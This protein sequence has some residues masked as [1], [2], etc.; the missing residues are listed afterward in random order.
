MLSILEELEGAGFVA[1]RGSDASPERRLGRP[2]AR[3]ALR[4]SAGV[5]LGLFLGREHLQVMVADL[6]LN[7]L[8]QGKARFE[9]RPRAKAMIRSA[10]ELTDAALEEAGVAQHA[11]VGT[12][13]GVPSPI[14]P[15]TGD[16]A[17]WT[18]EGWVPA[19]V[20]ETLS[21]RLGAPVQFENDANVEL[22]AEL[23]S[24][25]G[26]GLRHVIYV[27]ADWGIGGAIVVDGR[28]RRGRLG[29]AGELGH[30]R[31]RGADGA[32]CTCGRRGCLESVGSG[33][34]LV[35]A[36]ALAH[37]NELGLNGL[38]DLALRGDPAARR[39]LTDAGEAIGDALAGL[40]TSMNP[41][42]VIIGGRLGIAG[43]PLVDAAR[44]RIARDV[45]PTIG[46]V[47]VLPAALGDVGGALGAASMVVRSGVFGHQID[48]R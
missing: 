12:V 4:P 30:L 15:G 37:G 31:V 13:L 48:L 45:H 5:A 17:P 14:D 33:W 46:P 44:R 35:A 7:V 19:R 23:A 22:L 2:A 43:S 8:A 34:A 36:L 3:L 42:A 21:R 10:L 41:E 24:G 6:A 18:L 20:R 16:A 29:T 38:V 32:L 25:A 1:V 11:L 9:R 47:D 27:R 26:R 28:L 40:C 39:A